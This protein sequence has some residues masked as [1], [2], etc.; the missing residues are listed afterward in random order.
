MKMLLLLLL[1]CTSLLGAP[2]KGKHKGTDSNPGK[3]V[4]WG[5]GEVV[6]VEEP[7]APENE[8]GPLGQPLPGGVATI[9]VGVMAVLVA[10][11][12]KSCKD[13]KVS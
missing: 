11:H 1:V 10:W 9:C 6:V 4:G 7:D 8:H 2:G 12:M 5:E 13:F 3:H